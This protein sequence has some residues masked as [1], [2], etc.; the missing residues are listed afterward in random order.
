MAVEIERKFLVPP[1]HHA[2]FVGRAGG[3]VMEQVYLSADPAHTTR[4]R[5]LTGPE[6]TT[7]VM[8][9][10]GPGGVA[11]PEF[12]FPIPLEQARGILDTLRPPGLHKTRHLV[13][14]EGYT[15]DVDV[16][17]VEGGR[18]LVVAE[19]EAATLEAVQAVPL[20]PWVGREV[21]GDPM[22]TMSQLITA[23]ARQR[24]HDVADGT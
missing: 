22:F 7:A 20:P 10:K 15:W 19:I 12:E 18:V 21:T 13:H 5:V 4:I 1:E 24:A 11:R 16:V 3:T 8:T 6:G 14:H 9:I 2:R 17:T 23:E